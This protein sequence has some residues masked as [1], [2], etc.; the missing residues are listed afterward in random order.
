MTWGQR[1]SSFYQRLLGKPGGKPIVKQLERCG[2]AGG[3]ND[4]QARGVE[5][6]A[7]FVHKTRIALNRS[8][9]SAV[10]C[11]ESTRA[12]GMTNRQEVKVQTWGPNVGNPTPMRQ[13]PGTGALVPAQKDA[14]RCGAREGRSDGSHRCVAVQTKVKRRKAA[15]S[16]KP[17]RSGEAQYTLE[18]Q[19]Y[20]RQDG[21]EVCWSYPGASA[22]SPLRR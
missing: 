10:R 1:S 15:A 14:K 20:W 19:L 6:P 7:D 16:G 4:E 3:S 2:P 22:G 12:T 18:M 11:T 13:G 9:R 5:R 21:H 17:A 8:G